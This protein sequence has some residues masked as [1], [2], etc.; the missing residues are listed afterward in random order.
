MLSVV[1]VCGPFIHAGIAHL[2]VGPSRAPGQQ[3][4]GGA[5]TEASGSLLWGPRAPGWE[6]DWGATRFPFTGGLHGT[7]GSSLSCDPASLGFRA[8]SDSC[9]S[10][11]E[12]PGLQWEQRAQGWF[13]GGSGR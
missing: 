8:E 6:V 5:C 13:L 7:V 1:G 11:T 3:W 9:L 12:F 4:G 2:S 10:H